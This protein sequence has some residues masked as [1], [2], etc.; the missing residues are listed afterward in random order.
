MMWQFCSAASLAVVVAWGK[1]GNR[2]IELLDQN[3]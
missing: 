3:L 2:L 1:H